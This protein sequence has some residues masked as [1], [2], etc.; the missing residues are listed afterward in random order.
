MRP[1][2]VDLCACGKGETEDGLWWWKHA[3]WML[4]GRLHKGYSGSRLHICLMNLAWQ[5]E[6]RITI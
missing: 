2:M 6:L 4:S 3:S 1:W 5:V